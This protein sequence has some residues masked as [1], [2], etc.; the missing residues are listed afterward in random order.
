M[1]TTE[2]WHTQAYTTKAAEMHT[3]APPKAAI[4]HVFMVFSEGKGTLRPCLSVF[5]V[6]GISCPLTHTAR[7]VHIELRGWNKV[8]KTSRSLHYFTSHHRVFLFRKA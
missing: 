7:R 6:V 3:H 1:L 5:R 8:E 2:D 4:G